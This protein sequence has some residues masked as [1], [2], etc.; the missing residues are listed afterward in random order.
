MKELFEGNLIYLETYK[1]VM[2]MKKGLMFFKNSYFRM[3]PE[4]REKEKAAI[5]A[6][7]LVNEFDIQAIL[8]KKLIEEV[9]NG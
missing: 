4:A 7:L 5:E 8:K 1:K 3:S 6:A 9:E 2:V